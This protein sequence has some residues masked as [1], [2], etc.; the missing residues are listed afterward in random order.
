[1][2]LGYPQRGE[3]QGGVNRFEIGAKQ[4]GTDNE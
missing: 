1:M 2:L 3:A 4:D